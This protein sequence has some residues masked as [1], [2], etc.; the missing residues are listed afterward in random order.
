[1]AAPSAGKANKIIPTSFVPPTPMEAPPRKRQS[2]KDKAAMAASKTITKVTEEE[3]PCLKG[4]Q[5]SR[6]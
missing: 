5:A 3:K 6:G 1:M 2:A 4:T